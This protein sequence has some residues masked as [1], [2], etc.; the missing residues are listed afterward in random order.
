[1]KAPATNSIVATLL[2]AVMASAGT[3]LANADGSAH[4]NVSTPAAETNRIVETSSSDLNLSRSALQILQLTQ[5]DMDESVTLS[6]IGSAGIF[7][8]SADQ[9]L[10]LNDLGVSSRVIQAMLAHDGERLA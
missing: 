4:A 6:F 9:I 8:L 7:K 5:A 1:M 10:Y 3:V 2:L